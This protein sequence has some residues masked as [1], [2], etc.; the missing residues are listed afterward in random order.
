M[1][2]KGHQNRCKPQAGN[3]DRLPKGSHAE[4]SISE[5]PGAAIPHA[6]IRAGAGR[7]TALSTATVLRGKRCKMCVIGYLS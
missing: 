1:D 4:A 6:G 3:S 5:E 7:V 2:M